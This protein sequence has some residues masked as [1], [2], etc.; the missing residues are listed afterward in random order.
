VETVK[1]IQ[2]WRNGVF[3]GNVDEETAKE[4]VASGK[5]AWVGEART[6]IENKG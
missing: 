2:V 1:R 4:M 6:M 3:M 5:W